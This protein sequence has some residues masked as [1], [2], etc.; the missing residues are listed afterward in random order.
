M[1]KPTQPFI[2]A[3]KTLQ[4][5][6]T[7]TYDQKVAIVAQWMHE[8]V[9]G[10]SRLGQEHK[11]FAGLKWRSVLEPWGRPQS[12]KVPSETQPVEFALFPSGN[13]FAEGYRA[14]IGRD[15]YDG[16]EEQNTPMKYIAHLWRAGYAVDTDYVDK[17][18]NYFDDARDL[19]RETRASDPDATNITK[20]VFHR[21][22]TSSPIIVAH[23]T[24]GPVY[25]INTSL[26]RELVNFIALHSE[27]KGFEV[28][29]GATPIPTVPT[30]RGLPLE[31][32]EDASRPDPKT[33]PGTS[34]PVAKPAAIRKP[35]PNQSS[36][37]G[38][39]I[40]RIVMHYTTSA[41]HEGTI[42][43]FANPASRVSA[44]YLTGRG[45]ELFQ[46]VSDDRKAWHAKGNNADTIGIENA[47]TPGQRLT[48]AQEKKLIELTK[49]LMAEY[50]I[51]KDRVT[52]HRFLGQ[53]TSCP[54]D[55]WRTKAELRRWVDEK[56]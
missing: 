53:S 16:W 39:P 55:L 10:N 8:S 50:K 28:A 41:N 17:V 13:F 21:F 52:A 32:S 45:G 20:F 33:P 15:V 1:K 3:V 49:W 36:R 14:F 54:G 30:F 26:T 37:N 6:D 12:I 51:P 5:F 40:R 29:N 43:W 18:A 27:T 46:F 44:H 47:A 19:L 35:T 56:L 11:N 48:P 38:V 34:E 4:T 22:G 42:D 2:N 24:E 31:E 23:D 7:F 9:N 25:K